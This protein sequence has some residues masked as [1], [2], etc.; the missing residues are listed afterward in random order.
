MLG[1]RGGSLRPE[2]CAGEEDGK[3]LVRWIMSDLIDRMEGG[4]G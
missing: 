4:I 3:G 1:V 2:Y